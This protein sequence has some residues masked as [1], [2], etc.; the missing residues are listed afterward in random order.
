MKLTPST[1]TEKASAARL[2]L[3]ISIGLLVLGLFLACACPGWFAVAGM[4]AV[5]PVLWGRSFV[6]LLGWSLTV[7]SFTSS[8]AQ[9]RQERARESAQQRAIEAYRR[10]KNSDK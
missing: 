8:V 3:A 9:F 1:L 4:F 5:V 10:A 6:R 2:G 7:L